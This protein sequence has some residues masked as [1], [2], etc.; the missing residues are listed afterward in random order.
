MTAALVRHTGARLSSV[1]QEMNAQATTLLPVYRVRI[2]DGNH[3]ASTERRLAVLHQC[4][5]GPLPG[6]VLVVL[7]PDLMLVT[8]IVPCEDG[9]A[10][11]RSLF[12][13]VLARVEPK[14]LWMGDRNFCTVSFL[15]GIGKR[16]SFFAIR[17]HGNFPHP[18]GGNAS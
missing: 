17:Q 14:E 6:H 11:E 8:D 13:Q 15:E 3:L 10:Q 7:D 2:I 16:K 18:L 5:A 12:A 1:V 4:W 9:H